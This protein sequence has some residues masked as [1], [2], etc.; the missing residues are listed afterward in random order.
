MKSYIREVLNQAFLRFFFR[1]PDYIPKVK[2]SS[3]VLA[4]QWLKAVIDKKDTREYLVDT[5]IGYGLGIE[6]PTD[7]EIAKLMAWKETGRGYTFFATALSDLVSR[8]SMIG[9]SEREKN[10]RS[11]RSLD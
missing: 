2:N 10:K 9:V 5:I 1:I 3:E 4:I 11:C 6:D 8:R 7:D